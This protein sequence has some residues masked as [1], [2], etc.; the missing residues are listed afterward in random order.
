MF[1]AEIKDCLF[2][3]HLMQTE[4]FEKKTP[5]LWRFVFFLS[6]SI[7]LNAVSVN[8]Q[9]FCQPSSS[10]TLQIKRYFNEEIIA[11]IIEIR[12]YLDEKLKFST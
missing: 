6:D 8:R 2:H 4:I 3:I 5:N 12:Q 7:Q 9:Y 10:L 11:Q 1:T